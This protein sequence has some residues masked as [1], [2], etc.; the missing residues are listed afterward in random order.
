MWGGPL[1]GTVVSGMD[2]IRQRS[3]LARGQEA[4]LG[5]KPSAC[6]LHARVFLSQCGLSLRAINGLLGR[7]E[8]GLGFRLSAGLV[9][10]RWKASS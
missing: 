2:P 1:K 10:R 6:A 3:L 4:P 7:R 5:W 8:E 9:T